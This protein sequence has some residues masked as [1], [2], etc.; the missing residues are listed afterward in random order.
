M[1][2]TQKSIRISAKMIAETIHKRN[3]ISHKGTYGHAMIVAGSF[4]KMG[5]AVLAAKACLRTGVGLL[6]MYIPKCGY[7]ILQTAVPEAM[8]VCDENELHISEGMNTD[9]YDVLGI[10][11]GIGTDAETAKVV[12][13][14]I[15]HFHKPMVIDADA[16]NI[17]SKNKNWLKWVAAES[18]F[19]P[20][21]VE[22]ERLVGKFEN[23]DERKLLQ[24]RFSKE[25][26]VYV[27]FKGHETFISSPNGKTYC[28]TT[29]NAGMAK[30]GNGDALTGMLTALLAQGYSAEHSCIAGVF[31]HGL[32]GDIVAKER[33][34]FSLLA[35]D[36]IDDI[37][38]AF[39]E[40]RN[41][42][43]GK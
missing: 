4:G 20:H 2:E 39:I 34:E 19:T 25:Y 22:F 1:K 40:I 36:L 11:C 8:V 41:G 15:Q 24:I 6:S 38:N 35:S 29:G 26:D 16:I 18:I 27:V 43:K 17:L 32:A 5:A 21:A 33:G 10:G 42:N 37:G 23:D 3:P 7:G 13:K 31:L 30:A 14:M 12:K 9:N 28:N